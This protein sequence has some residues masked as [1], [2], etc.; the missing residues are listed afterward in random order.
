MGEPA[1]PLDNDDASNPFDAGLPMLAGG[2]YRTPKPPPPPKP[3]DD[4]HDD[5]DDIPVGEWDDWIAAR[6]ETHTPTVGVETTHSWDIPDFDRPDDYDDTEGA[7]AAPVLIDRTGG[8]KTTRTR[9][10]PRSRNTDRGE[11]DTTRRHGKILASVLAGLGLAVILAALV[12]NF[13]ITPSRSAKSDSPAATAAPMMDLAAS[14]PP[15]TTSA[16]T[17]TEVPTAALAA[18][19]P[20]CEQYATDTEVSGTGLGDA[21]TPAGVILAWEYA[22][23]QARSGPDAAALVADGAIASGADGSRQDL[24]PTALQAAIDAVPEGTHYCVHATHSSGATWTLDL[25][26]Q[27]PTDPAPMTWHQL[28]TRSTDTGRPRNSA[29]ASG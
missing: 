5:A 27:F 23:Y 28:L 13:V 4:D 3:P 26:E 6:T 12:I 14:T 7:R 24:T 2:A 17:R 15:P 10:R 16:P 29:I 9:A 19:T 20:G 25:T 11:V 8:R 1:R 22:Y 18:A 21:T